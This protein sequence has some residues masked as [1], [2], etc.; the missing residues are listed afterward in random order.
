MPC[1]YCLTGV[2]SEQCVRCACR[3]SFTVPKCGVLSVSAHLGLDVRHRLYLRFF[4]RGQVSLVLSPFSPLNVCYMY[5]MF[6]VKFV[7]LS[8]MSVIHICYLKVSKHP[9]IFH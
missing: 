8:H 1:F 5:T 3:K 2:V 7:C 6:P 4:V 9:F